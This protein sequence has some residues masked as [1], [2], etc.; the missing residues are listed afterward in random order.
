[1]ERQQSASDRQD[2]HNVTAHP[3]GELDL[4]LPD[5]NSAANS[6]PIK[7]QTASGANGPSVLDIVDPEK[8][9]STQSSLHIHLGWKASWRTQT[10]IL[11]FF[12]LCKC[13]TNP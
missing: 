11:G 4:M 2:H 7:A 5:D 10:V 8:Y 13:E 1:V 3:E 6:L 12:V 9:Q